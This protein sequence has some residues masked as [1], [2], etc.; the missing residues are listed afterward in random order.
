MRRGARQKS[1]RFFGARPS[2]VGTLMLILSFMSRAQGNDYGTFGPA[3][4]SKARAVGVRTV[5]DAVRCVSF[6]CQTT[7]AKLTCGME[8]LQTK[9]EFCRHEMS[10]SYV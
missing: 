9:M 6:S 5:E 10:K 7:A 4:G 1:C 2:K 8:N 3:S